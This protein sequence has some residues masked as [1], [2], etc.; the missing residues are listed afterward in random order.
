MADNIGKKRSLQEMENA[1]M[2]GD[3]PQRPDEEMKHSDELD[4]LVG[5]DEQFR[6]EE[7]EA[8]DLLGDNEKRQESEGEG[9][10][11]MDKM[12]QD[13]MYQRDERLDNYEPVGINDDQKN[14]D[15][16]DYNQRQE[17]ER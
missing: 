9:D 2:S 16:L 1:D 7:L 3:S 8:E 4:P 13:E 6:D 14:I 17:V 5:D 10:D 15:E 12:E 11:I